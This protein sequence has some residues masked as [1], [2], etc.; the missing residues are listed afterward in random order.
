MASLLIKTDGFRN[1]VLELKLGSNRLGRSAQNDFQI[2]H[3]T[4]SARH[5]E[6]VLSAEGVTVRDCGSSNGTF[7][8][9]KPIREGTIAAGQVLRLGEIELLVESTDVRIAIP[10]FD[11]PRPAPPVVLSDGGIA[12]RCSAMSASDGYA[13]EAG[14]C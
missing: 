11:M 8:D 12:A 5:C 6:L 14:S 4:V 7:L 10:K 13:G 9:G 2:E 3:P 1:Q